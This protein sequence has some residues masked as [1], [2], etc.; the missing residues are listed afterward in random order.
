MVDDI[1]KEMHYFRSL[2]NEFVDFIKKNDYDLEIIKTDEI[3]MEFIEYKTK[4]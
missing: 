4:R 3:S 1:I 2:L